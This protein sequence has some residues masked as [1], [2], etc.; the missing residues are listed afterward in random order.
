MANAQKSIEKLPGC[1]WNIQE[2]FQY[3]CEILLH[4]A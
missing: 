3:E 4:Q 2:R 1:K